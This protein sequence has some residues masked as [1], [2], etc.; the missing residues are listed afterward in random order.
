VIYETEGDMKKVIMGGSTKGIEPLFRENRKTKDMKYTDQRYPM[1][2]TEKEEAGRRYW[3]VAFVADGV[4]ASSASVGKL[5]G[6]TKLPPAVDVLFVIDGTG[7]MDEFKDPTIAAVRSIQESMIDYW[8]QHFKA[9]QAP[10]LRFSVTMYKDYQETDYYRR[11]PVEERNVG[12][13]AEFL[14]S[15]DF[16]GGY[17]QPA[18]FHG[19]SNAVK[20]ASTELSKASLRAVFLVGDMGNLGVSTEQDQNGHTIDSV[21]RIL[22]SDNMDFH[23]IHVGTEYV[24]DV[25][26]PVEI[27][28]ALKRFKTETETIKNRLPEGR[29]SYIA[30]SDPEKVTDHIKEKVTDILDQRYRAIGEIIDVATTGKAIG[31][32][33]IGQRAIQLMKQNGIDPKEF[34]QKKVTPFF[35]GWATPED[36]ATGKRQLKPVILMEKREVE[37]LIAVLGRLTTIKAENAGKGWM[38]ALEEV[39]GDD[40]KIGQNDSPADLFRKHLGIKVKSGILSKSFDEISNLPQAEIAEAVKDFAEKLM[41]LRGVVNEKDVKTTTDPKTGRPD[42]Q[43]VG[44]KKYWFGHRGALHVWLDRDIFIP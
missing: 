8:Q 1:I 23:A 32:T 34:A 10:V 19:V 35:E 2:T 43:I 12:E 22:E 28:N 37:N 27:Q 39:A 26:V 17:S 36:L 15:H 29:S 42:F 38:Q 3:N 9:E 31:N 24:N 4:G 11:T 13:I 7:S 41:L 5:G 40:I 14:N 6:L 18:V 21:V 25:Q 20:D 44:D 33:L 16:S 30:L